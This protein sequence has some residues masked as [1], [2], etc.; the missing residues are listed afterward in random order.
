MEYEMTPFEKEMEQNL[1]EMRSVLLSKISKSDNDFRNLVGS[2]VLALAGDP[3]VDDAPGLGVGV[4]GS[5]A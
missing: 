4:V 3:A 5:D 2:G 1:L